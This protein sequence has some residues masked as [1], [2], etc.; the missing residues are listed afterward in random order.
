MPGTRLN[1]SSTK[2]ETTDYT[3]GSPRSP[4]RIRAQAPGRYS[5]RAGQAHRV[6][7]L[8][9]RRL[10]L[11]GFEPNTCLRLKPQVRAGSSFP[12]ATQKERCAKPSAEGRFCRIRRSAR[13]DYPWAGGD[14]V[15][16]G[17]YAEKFGAAIPDPRGGLI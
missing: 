17:E 13:G 16:S 6:Q 10:S 9:N 2:P 8:Q 3:H 5:V 14:D 12:P 7:G 4:W 11:R 15:L 1:R